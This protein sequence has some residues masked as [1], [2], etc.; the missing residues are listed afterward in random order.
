[1]VHITQLLCPSRHCILATAYES[2]KGSAQQAVELLQA[3]ASELKIHPWCGIC[4]STEL[5]YED[6]A[7]PFR[8]LSQAMPTLA[9]LQ[10]A[11]LEAMQLFAQLPKDN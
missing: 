8:T 3:T 4:G 10:K 1:M 5:V 9:S 2:E 7:T 11:N 6:R